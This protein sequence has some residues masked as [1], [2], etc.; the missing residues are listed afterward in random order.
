MQSAKISSPAQPQTSSASLE[1]AAA[2]PALRQ[3]Q[4]KQQA[5]VLQQPWP[6]TDTPPAAPCMTHD[7]SAAKLQRMHPSAASQRDTV[8]AQ[9]DAAAAADLFS[10]AE[11][12]K[13]QTTE[14][15]HCSISDHSGVDKLQSSNQAGAQ[16]DAVDSL[17]PSLAQHSLDTVNSLP[18]AASLSACPA[19]PLAAQLDQLA[20]IQ[21]HFI[22][23]S[24]DADLQSHS[25]DGSQDADEDWVKPQCQCDSEL[26]ANEAVQLSVAAQNAEDVHST[27]LSHEQLMRPQTAWS[28]SN[29]AADSHTNP[30][31]CSESDSEGELG[32]AAEVSVEQIHWLPPHFF[33]WQDPTGRHNDLGL[34]FEDPSR[35]DS[36]G[37]PGTWSWAK[38]P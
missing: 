25:T 21:S 19:A 3:Q 6:Q 10:R 16:Y 11:G 31:S 2:Q 7:Q 12:A 36:E 1:G 13:A 9:A 34:S 38:M 15:R 23:G 5:D 22:D 8:P 26:Q 27:S 35:Q 18:A 24:Q 33:R 17:L 37:G 14:D 20:D 30:G 32:A 4:D 28:G 29:S